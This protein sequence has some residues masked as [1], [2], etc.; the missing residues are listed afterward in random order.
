MTKMKTVLIWSALGV[1]SF[2]LG[3]LVA[4]T[5]YLSERSKELTKEIEEIFEDHSKRLDALEAKR[6]KKEELD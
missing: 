5:Q 4:H 3:R 2:H 6:K 1:G